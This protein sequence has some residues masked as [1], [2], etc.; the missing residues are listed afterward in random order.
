MTAPGIRRS[1]GGH[2]QAG[3]PQPI[4]TQLGHLNQE[5]LLE[6]HS[7][8]RTELV[9]RRYTPRSPDNSKPSERTGYG[10]M[11]FDR[12]MDRYPGAMGGVA[13]T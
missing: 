4:S 13:V 8:R 2:L 5:V 9:Q 1:V 11:R 6:L 3:R 7:I 10:P 12:P